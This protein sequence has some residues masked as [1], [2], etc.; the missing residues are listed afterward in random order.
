MNKGTATCIDTHL[1]RYV[2]LDQHETTKHKQWVTMAR[3]QNMEYSTGARI[4]RNTNTTDN[5]KEPHTQKQTHKTNIG[6]IN[7]NA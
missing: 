7:P 6:M 3:T 5:D 4:R 1:K 2:R